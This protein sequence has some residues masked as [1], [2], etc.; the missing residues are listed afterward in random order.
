MTD[1]VALLDRL[2]DFISRDNETKRAQLHKKWAMPLGQRVARGYAIEGITIE[3]IKADGKIG[4]RCYRNE[5]RF[6]EG[7]FVV[8]HRGDPA[9]SEAVETVLEFDAETYLEVRLI[10]EKSFLLKEHDVGW[11]IDESML[12]LTRFYRDVLNEVADTMRGREL[13]LPLIC[14]IRAPNID[15]AMYER[16]W[17]DCIAV[18]LNESQ[19]EATA[20]AYASD[21]AYLIHGPP[22]TG[23]TFVLAHLARLLVADG[24]R[25]LVTALTHRAINNA[26]NKIQTIDPALPICKVGMSNR[27]ADLNVD[28]VENFSES[29][30]IDLNGGYIVGATPFAT[31]TFRLSNVD[32]DIILF[33]E[34]SQVT[35]PLA[36]MG[37]LAG[38]KYVFIGDEK[39]LPP[40]TSLAASD[41]GAES[42]FGYLNGRGY[43]T[44]LTTTYRLND[45][46][47]EWPSRTF[48]EGKI[49]PD[50]TV[51]KRRLVLSSIDERWKEVLEPQRPSVFLDVGH[52]GMTI[53]CRKEAELTCDLIQAL[54]QARVPSYDIGVVVPYRA[55]ARLIRNL[56]RRLHPDSEICREIIVDTVERMQG[57]EREVVLIS[58]TTSN[59]AFA[60]YLADFYFQPERLNVA[61]TR[62]RTKLIILGSHYVLDAEP[63]ESM[64][65]AWVDL[66]KDLLSNCYT[67]TLDGGRL[68]VWRA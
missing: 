50:P 48:Y 3:T 52:H 38:A 30:F 32:F 49:V 63:E 55:Q 43:E 68:G 29:G 28:N 41:E 6:R 23:K 56:L 37:M 66:M 31:R 34:A 58:L 60:E 4:L 5:S 62:P 24:Q 42:I 64:A 27:A 47:A 54:L 13:I 21:L 45:K 40:V 59:P 61:I 11:I 46:L 16:A 53:R 22:G 44:M 17:E 39:Q 14:G 33:D 25:V 19:A 65:Q 36:I 15:Y 35:L 8:L 7:D 18:G 26:L 51:A 67:I 2:K 57:Q 20:M 12:D 9:G 1:Y 10:D